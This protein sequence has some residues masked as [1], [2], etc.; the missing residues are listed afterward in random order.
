MSLGQAGSLG[1]KEEAVPGTPEDTVDIFFST[2]P[3]NAL[4]EQE[5]IEREANIQQNMRLPGKAGAKLPQGNQKSELMAN[6]GHPFYWALGNISVSQPD[7][8]SAPTV[9]RHTATIDSSLPSLTC[10]AD[11]VDSWKKQAG[12]KINKINLAAAFGEIVKMDFDWFGLT[13]AEPGSFSSSPTFINDPLCFAG[14]DISIGGES[15]TKVSTLDMEINND[16]E[17]I[18]ALNSTVS[19]AQV[20]RKGDGGSL[21]VTG[22]L[23]FID[24]VATEYA[25]LLAASTVAM[26]FTFQGVTA[27]TGAFFPYVKIT[28]PAVQYKGGLNPEIGS[29]VITDEGDFEAHYDTATSSGIT[30]EIQNTVASL[31]I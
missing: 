26:I 31:T 27:I 25:R 2:E 21:M 18:G 22:K 29:G 16:L 5:P 13:Q 24:Y 14:I 1:F 19:A 20:R 17:Q 8:T 28:L 6:R 3:F 15:S 30:V 10:E 7:T 11:K 12:V 9:Y 23:G 4:Q